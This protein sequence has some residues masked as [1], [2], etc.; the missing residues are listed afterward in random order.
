MSSL[1]GGPTRT[2]PTSPRPGPEVAA[3]IPL[4]TA[5]TLAPHRLRFSPSPLCTARRPAAWRNSIDRQAWLSII[6]SERRGPLSAA[7]RGLLRVLSWLYALAVAIRSALF[8]TG[9]ARTHRAPVPVV[10]VGNL[11]A[12]GTGKTPLTIALAER[13]VARGERVFVLARGYGA[14]RPGELNDE[15][16]LVKARVPAVSVLA[17]SDRAALAQRAAREGATVCLLDDGFQHRR[18]ARDVDVLVVDATDPWGAGYLLPRGLL[19]EPVHAA[20]RAGFVVISRVE[21]APE[22][23]VAEI[24][25]RLAREGVAAPVAL[26]R[27]EPGEPRPLGGAAP[28]RPGELAT[29]PVA[30]LAAIG[31]PGAFR[32]TVESLGAR[33]V[34]GVALP[35]HHRFEPRDLDEARAAFERATARPEAVLVTEKDAVKLAS[36]L[37]A[38]PGCLGR[39]VHAVPIDA[40]LEEDGPLAAALEALARPANA[41][42]SSR[43]PSPP[44]ATRRSLAGAVPGAMP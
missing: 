2:E 17:G 3:S 40:R 43:A 8:R 22:G 30:L 44:R 19:R 4:R 41:P 14:A 42:D 18:L 7:A 15:L 34:A 33:V 26:M 16:E 28:L 25:E 20:R 36:L 39:P 1:V 23:R 12:G 13:L 35:D 37:A 29:K 32:A 9:L 10:S 27:L 38:D 6:R 11:T 24:R 5:L 31:N 21:Q